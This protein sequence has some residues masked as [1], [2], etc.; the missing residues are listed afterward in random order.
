MHT[1][2]HQQYYVHIYYQSILAHLSRSNIITKIR[3]CDPKNEGEAGAHT[4]GGPRLRKT[5][6]SIPDPALAND[7]RPLG[8]RGDL[9]DDDR[10]SEGGRIASA[11]A[12]PGSVGREV[13]DMF[14]LG[15]GALKETGRNGDG[16]EAD[17]E[18]C[19]VTRLGRRSFCRLGFLE[20]P[21]SLLGRGSLPPANAKHDEEAFGLGVCDEFGDRLGEGS[22]NNCSSSSSLMDTAG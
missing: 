10:E 21:M 14:L 1:Y 2:A 22:G 6:F 20:I 7:V 9:A 19:D 18:N 5:P 11:S 15:R 3:V 4:G 17:E 8:E 16:N 13:N 12:I